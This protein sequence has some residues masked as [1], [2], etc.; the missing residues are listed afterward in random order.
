M[1]DIGLVKLG[2][3]GVLAL[4][5]FGDRLP[6]VARQAGRTLREVRAMADAAR[7]GM[8]ESLGPGFEDFDPADLH[9]N[10]FLRKHLF[11][12][13]PP[14]WPS[15]TGTPRAAVPSPSTPLIFDDAPPPFD[16]EAT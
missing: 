12:D 15:P 9:P 2:V 14:S 16:D 5:I 10:T 13:V 8:R 3:L 6:E 1:F 11:D 7:Q 4:L